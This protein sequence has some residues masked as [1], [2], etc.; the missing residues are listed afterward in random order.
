VRSKSGTAIAGVLLSYLSQQVSNK[1]EATMKPLKLSLMVGALSLTF[2]GCTDPV[3]RQ[4]QQ[5][6]ELREAKDRLREAEIRQ[7]EESQKAARKAAEDAQPAVDKAREE[8]R[9]EAK[10][11]NEAAQDV[12]KNP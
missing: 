6:R 9:E 12:Q 10:D 11:V 5:E 3:E 1:K 4:Q 2:V 7:Q 8:V